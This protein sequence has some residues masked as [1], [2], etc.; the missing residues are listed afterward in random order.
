MIPYC[1]RCLKFIRNH[2]SYNDY[3]IE[4]LVNGCL[5]S[6]LEIK[7]QLTTWNIGVLAAARL[8]YNWVVTFLSLSL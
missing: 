6:Q 2:T 1:N 8:P 3:S 4:V 7:V 5:A